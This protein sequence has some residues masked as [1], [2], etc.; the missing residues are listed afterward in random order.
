[1]RTN[2]AKESYYSGLTPPYHCKNGPLDSLEEML[3]IKGVTP[4]LLFGNDKNRN[5]VARRRRGAAGRS[6]S[7]GRP[8]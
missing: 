4:Q 6:I 8:T 2:G 3:L 7:A 1:M 5:G